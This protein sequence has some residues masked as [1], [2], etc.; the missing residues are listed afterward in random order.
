M[1]SDIFYLEAFRH[2]FVMN[3][4]ERVRAI[5]HASVEES[6]VTRG[7]GSCPASQALCRLAGVLPQLL[8]M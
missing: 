3:A 4:A 5:Y 8:T 1:F 6:I 7:G 2:L